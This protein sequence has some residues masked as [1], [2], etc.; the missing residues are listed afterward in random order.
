LRA[1]DLIEL[2]GQDLRRAP[3]ER[4]KHKLT[5]LIR[6]PHPG[7]DLRAHIIYAMIPIS[8][9][10]YRSMRMKSRWRDAG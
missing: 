7:I 10:G 6:T 3:I 1:F 9:R 8:I 2:D 4:R 5:K